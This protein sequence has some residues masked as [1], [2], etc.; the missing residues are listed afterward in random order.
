[1]TEHVQAFDYHRDGQGILHFGLCDSQSEVII[2]E[3][4]PKN[5]SIVGGAILFLQRA[6]AVGSPEVLALDEGPI[7]R[8]GSFA[9]FVKIE[10]VKLRILSPGDIE[11]DILSREMPEPP[12][13]GG[14]DE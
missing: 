4:V 6:W 5:V 3:A 2:T 7:G 10:G 11:H 1:M 9:R 12:A 14:N 8:A 13:K